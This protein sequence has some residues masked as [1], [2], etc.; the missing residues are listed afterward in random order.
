MLLV[1]HVFHRFLQLKESLGVRLIAFLLR[2]ARS[3]KRKYHRC[4]QQRT[5]GSQ[6]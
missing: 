3:G 4:D 6:L 5:C 1:E 2:H